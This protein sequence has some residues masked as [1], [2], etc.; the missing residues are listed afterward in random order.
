MR[1]YFP[2]L[3]AGRQDKPPVDELTMSPTDNLVIVDVWAR[4]AEFVTV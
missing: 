4:S 1:R 2:Q 3:V